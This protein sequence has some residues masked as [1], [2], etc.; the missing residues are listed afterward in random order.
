M[1][2]TVSFSM[3]ENN[4]RHH[5]RLRLFNAPAFRPG[6]LR[7]PLRGEVSFAAATNSS[8]RF[9]G[10]DNTPRMNAPAGED[11]RSRTQRAIKGAA[12]GKNECAGS[13]EAHVERR[14]LTERLGYLEKLTH[15]I[16]KDLK[17]TQRSPILINK[18]VGLHQVVRPGTD[19]PERTLERRFHFLWFARDRVFDLERH[20]GIS[21]AGLGEHG[22]VRHEN[23]IPRL[24]SLSTK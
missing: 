5:F 4:N 21:P 14:Q 17:W 16:W 3:G 6:A 18:R 11:T 7:L 24:L 23:V 2:W 15:E 19:A 9:L 10:T 13:P 12:R 20:E 8:R 22:Q 1:G